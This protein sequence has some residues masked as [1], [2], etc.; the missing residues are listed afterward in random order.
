VQFTQ[1]SFRQKR[2]TKV[3]V[4]AT[5][6]SP[7]HTPSTRPPGPSILSIGF[8]YSLFDVGRSSFSVNPRPS[9]P[10]VYP[11][12]RNPVCSLLITSYS[13]VSCPAYWF[14]RPKEPYKP[15]ELYGLCFRIHHSMLDVRC[16]MFI[17]SLVSCPAYRPLLTVYFLYSLLLT[18]YFLLLTVLFCLLVLSTQ[19]T[20]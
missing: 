16:S 5:T 12:V 1:D 8:L 2:V 18:D 7:R 14:Y 4:D 11:V 3:S 15:K 10:D 17:F 6:S 13:L 19:R 9:S 20:L